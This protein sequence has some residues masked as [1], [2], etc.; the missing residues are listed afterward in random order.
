MTIESTPGT[1]LAK[2]ATTCDKIAGWAVEPPGHTH[3]HLDV[4]AP[5]ATFEEQQAVHQAIK[6]V[7]AK[8]GYDVSEIPFM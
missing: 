3:L 4:F 6:D 5:T 1:P 2:R 8:F 7:L